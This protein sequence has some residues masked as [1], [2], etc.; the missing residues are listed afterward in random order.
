M[1]CLEP[2]Y[3]KG[4]LKILCMGSTFVNRINTKIEMFRSANLA[5]RARNHLNS[6]VCKIGDTLT[7]QRIALIG[8]I[9]R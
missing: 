8:H 1:S 2:F 9:L 5:I 7:K 4:F 6:A 3:F